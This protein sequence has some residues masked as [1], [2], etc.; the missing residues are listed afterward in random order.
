MLGLSSLR[1]ALPEAEVDR[2]W[3]KAKINGQP[4]RLVFDSGSNAS[5]LTSSAAQRLGLRAQYAPT[6]DVRH[7]VVAGETEEFTFSLGGAKWRTSFVLLDPHF[8]EIMSG[9]GIVGWFT[10]S[11][12]VIGVAANAKS[13]AF[14]D[15]VPARTASWTQLS[16]L[17]NFGTLDLCVPRCNHTNGVLCVDTGDARGLAL[18]A[19]EWNRWRR[20]HPQIPVT[21]EAVFSPTD[22]FLVYEEAWADQISIGPITITGL[23]V[24]QSGH[25]NERRLGSRYEGTLGLAGLK[26]LNLIV[27]GIHS[28]AYTHP[29]QAHA[30]GY[31]H[32]RLGAVFFPTSTRTNEAVAMVAENSPAYE[33]GVRDGDILVRVDG[34][35]VKYT[36]NS[37]QTGFHRPAGSRLRLTLK[38]GDKTFTATATL[39]EIVSPDSE[40]REPRVAPLSH[41]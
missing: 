36:D 23:P 37:W 6:N 21:V 35:A 28:I 31:D 26:R 16:V 34:A 11:H 4:V 33:A 2:I 5:L 17:T 40:R 12:N 10:L 8:S 25:A 22:G 38:R 9:D 24:A 7:S 27:D 3:L 1:A 18:P 32:N 13:L 20:T 14:F 19:G 39:R 29:D 15:R 30:P 41:L